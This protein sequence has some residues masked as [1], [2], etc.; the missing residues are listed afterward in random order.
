MPLDLSEI[1]T[2]LNALPGRVEK[3]V[4]AY[5]QTTAKAIEANAKKDRPWTDRTAQARQRLHGD[6][7]HIDTGIRISLSH[8]VAYGVYL[9][10][11]HE[12]RYAI[13]YP[14]LREGSIKTSSLIQCPYVL[15]A[16]KLRCFWAFL[17]FRA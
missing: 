16:R 4:A 17:R 9:E 8:G 2:S 15:L 10:F 6:C 5:G 14:V 12:K 1:Y 3:A 13:I 11:A 7:T